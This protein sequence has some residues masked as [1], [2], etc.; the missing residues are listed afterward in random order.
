MKH[1]TF[2]RRKKPVRRSVLVAAH[3]LRHGPRQDSY[4]DPTETWAEVAQVWSTLAGVEITGERAALMM[5]ALK[6]VRANRRHDFDDLAD[7]AA[8]LDIAND[9]RKP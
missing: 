6:V 2:P 4:G 7:G 8:Y 5:T 9:F 3:Q 1:P